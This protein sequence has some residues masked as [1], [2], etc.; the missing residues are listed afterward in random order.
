MRDTMNTL[1]PFPCRMARAGKDQGR[2]TN[3]MGSV[4]VKCKEWG[5][6][7][8]VESCCMD[9]FVPSPLFSLGQMGKCWGSSRR[10]LCPFSNFNFIRF[11][12]FR[13]YLWPPY[14]APVAVRPVLRVRIMMSS[15]NENKIH[16]GLNFVLFEALFFLA[17][18]SHIKTM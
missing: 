4:S 12:F 10:I 6:S 9:G 11:Q 13:N 5:Q 14:M 15:F 3:R 1:P 8:G 2:E 16:Q 7:N 17:G 18:I